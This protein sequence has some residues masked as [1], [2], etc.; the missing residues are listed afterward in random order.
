MVCETVESSANDAD[1]LVMSDVARIGLRRSF[2]D[3]GVIFDREAILTI[4]DSTGE[5]VNLVP[6]RR[7][8]SGGASLLDAILYDDVSVS[9]RASLDRAHMESGELLSE[10]DDR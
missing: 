8:V 1:I 10:A 3:G 9:M 7:D 5:D 2:E 4:L 6:S